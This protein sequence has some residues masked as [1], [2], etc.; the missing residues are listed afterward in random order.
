MSMTFTRRALIGGG[1]IAGL[2]AI[3]Y[4]QR[5]TILSKLMEQAFPTDYFEPESRKPDEWEKIAEGVYTFK[6]GFNRTMIVD[7]NDGIA[8]FDT[9]NTKLTTK[10]KDIIAKNLPGKAVKW[11]FYSHNHFDHIRGAQVLSPQ[12]IVGHK[13]VNK[14]IADFPHAADILRVTQP[15]ENDTELK[16]GTVTLRMLHLPQ[17]H[18]LTMYAAHLPERGVVY[19]PDLMFVR[20]MPPFGFPDWYYPGYIKAL[21]RIISLDAKEYVPAHFARGTKQDLI[22]YRNMMVDFR[23]TVMEE[24]K[25]SNFEAGNGITIRQAFRNALPRL[26]EKYGHWTGFQ[27]MFVPHFAGQVG[28]S[29]LGY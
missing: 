20:A 21:D 3:G 7:S 19:A 11:V 4:S 5:H 17:S 13:D 16:I 10:L 26:R 12:I 14:M 1:A 23:E 25:K 29:Y 2:A 22:D 9:F 18:S 15:I 28:G 8:V 6:H 24:L 27:A